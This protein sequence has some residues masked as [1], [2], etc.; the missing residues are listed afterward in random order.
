[1]KKWWTETT[2]KAAR[3]S[4]QPVKYTHTRNSPASKKF[5]VTLLMQKKR[6]EWNTPHY[7]PSHPCMK[8]NWTKLN[9]QKNLLSPRDCVGYF[10]TFNKN[11][12]YHRINYEWNFI[13]IQDVRQQVIHSERSFAFVSTNWK[14][15]EKKK[16]NINIQVGEIHNKQRNEYTF[17]KWE[18]QKK[19]I[20]ISN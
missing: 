2:L 20:P 8:A 15:M 10:C 7:P 9:F 16:E 11:F 4:K 18:W 1:M 6:L 3:N 5:G 14:R 13:E 12:I 17:K 19:T